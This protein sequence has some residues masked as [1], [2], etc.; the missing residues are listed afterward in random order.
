MNEELRIYDVVP[1]YAAGPHKRGLLRIEAPSA[2]QAAALLYEHTG[3]FPTV[4]PKR[5]DVEGK[6]IVFPGI[7]FRWADRLGQ[8]TPPVLREYVITEEV[9]YRVPAQ[10]EGEAREIFLQA[11]GNEFPCSVESCYVE[12][13]EGGHESDEGP[14]LKITRNGQ[15]VL[16]YGQWEEDSN[17]A[18]VFDNEALDGIWA[19][20]ADNWIEVVEHLT[21]YAAKNGTKLVELNAC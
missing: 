5:A 8:L 11:G 21:L 10:S 19:D 6:G 16:C 15:E 3:Y 7:D 1:Q 13:S 18:C 9:S 14:V 17:C 2:L 4:L 12:P 20:G